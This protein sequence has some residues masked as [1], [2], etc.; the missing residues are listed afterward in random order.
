VRERGYALD[1]REH[2]ANMRCIAVP[3]LDRESRAVAALSAT[4]DA[5][6]MTPERLLKIRNALLDAAASLRQKLYPVPVSIQYRRP[7]A[8]E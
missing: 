8:A 2:Q 4:D 1:D 5:E 3:V 6:R 7:I